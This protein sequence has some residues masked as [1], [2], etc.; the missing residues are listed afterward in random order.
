MRLQTVSLDR[1]LITK[2]TGGIQSSHMEVSAGI[3]RQVT[4]NVKAQEHSREENP[5][6]RHLQGSILKRIWHRAT[7]TYVRSRTWES[8]YMQ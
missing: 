8:V 1:E 7:V 5:K 3:R 2:R 6:P 4:I